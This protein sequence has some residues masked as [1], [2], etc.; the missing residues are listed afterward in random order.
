VYRWN[1]AKQLH[2][3][4]KR[5]NE[6]GA[7]CSLQL[8]ERVSRYLLSALV[9]K[10]DAANHALSV[11]QWAGLIGLQLLRSLFMDIL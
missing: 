11:E 1:Q 8:Q 6:Y 7:V 9:F 10:G 4:V 2:Y 3:I 5:F